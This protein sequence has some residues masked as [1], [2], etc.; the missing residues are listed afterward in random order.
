MFTE[1]ISDEGGGLPRGVVQL[2][3]HVADLEA[4]VEVHHRFPTQVAEAAHFEQAVRG[5][6]SGLWLSNRMSPR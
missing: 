1:E 5:A 4:V 2:V 6:V 3:V